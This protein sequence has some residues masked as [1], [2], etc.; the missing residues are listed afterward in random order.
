MDAYRLDTTSIMPPSPLFFHKSLVEFYK[1]QIERQ[2]TAAQ[3]VPVEIDKASDQLV[4]VSGPVVERAFGER[5]VKRTVRDLCR[6]STG[7]FGTVRWGGL[8]LIVRKD[9][10][11]EGWWVMEQSPQEEV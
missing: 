5:R 2:G 1:G 9:E 10:W 4:V 8:S 3:I 7:V 6:Y 11:W